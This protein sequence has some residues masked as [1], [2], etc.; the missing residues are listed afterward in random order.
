MKTTAH[1]STL[2]KTAGGH[3]QEAHAPRDEADP[4]A[5][6]LWCRDYRGKG[7]TYPEALDFIRSF[8]GH[9]A[10]GLVIG[11]KMVDW[12]R[13]QLPDDI[14]FDVVCETNSCLPDAVQMLTP[15]TIGNNWLKIKNLGRLALTLYDKFSGD[16]MRVFIDPAKLKRWPEFFAWVYKRKPKAD[17]DFDRLLEEIRQA[18]SDCLTGTPVAIDPSYRVKNS[19]G[20]IS[21][22]PLCGEAYPV[23]HGGICRGCQGAA[24]YAQRHVVQ[25]CDASQGPALKVVPVVEAA[26]GQVLHDMTQVVPAQQKDPVL[27]QGQLIATGDDCGRCRVGRHHGRTNGGSG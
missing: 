11:L 25:P 21:T 23:N 3:A 9:L 10:P 26:G 7:Y 24:P 12:A 6:A 16:G 15:C 22:C 4:S 1:Q 17:Q 14:L 8:H 19:K 13:E 20:P 27:R 18:G 2:P 5:D